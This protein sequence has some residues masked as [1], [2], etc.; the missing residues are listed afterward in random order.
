MINKMLKRIILILIFI[1]LAILLNCSSSYANGQGDGYSYQGENY[2][3]RCY[4]LNA[5]E[6][7]RYMYFYD[8]PTLF[9]NQWYPQQN[10]E[11]TVVEFLVDDITIS[12]TYNFY[13]SISFKPFESYGAD[14]PYNGKINF[15]KVTLR[16]GQY[17]T[18]TFFRNDSGAFIFEDIIFDGGWGDNKNGTIAYSPMLTLTGQGDNYLINCTLKN[19]C[20]MSTSYGGAISSQNA[21]N[22][23]TLINVDITNCQAYCGGAMFLGNTHLVYEGGEI[24]KCYSTNTGVPNASAISAEPS[25]SDYRLTLDGV[26]ITECMALNATIGGA[27]VASNRK[28][29]WEIKNIEITNNYSKALKAGF[30]IVEGNNEHEMSDVHITGDIIIDDNYGNCTFNGYEV[31]TKGAEANLCCENTT[32][33]LFIYLDCDFTS[34]TRCGVSTQW[35]QSIEDNDIVYWG[36]AYS[37]DIKGL[38]Y[39]FCDEDT[40]YKGEYLYDYHHFKEIYD[41]FAVFQT[42]KQVVY[43]ET[44]TLE[45][46][47]VGA[48]VD[49]TKKYRYRI[50][51][52]EDGVEKTVEVELSHDEKHTVKVDKNTEY[53]IE[54]LDDVTEESVEIIAEMPSGNQT[55]T[56]IDYRNNSATGKFDVDGSGKVTYIYTKEAAP[57]TGITDNLS[58]ILPIA[59]LPVTVVL[60]N[61]KIKFFV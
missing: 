2:Q 54:L 43:K 1:S 53:K 37:K 21:N 11:H 9:N 18:G 16:R 15:N 33:D 34:A 42:K 49:I 6:P 45:H 3:L 32:V 39:F 55:I 17:F 44:L 57:E 59:I 40:S 23:L 19:N 4:D 52:I 28:G 14:D 38:E 61:K 58:K 20:N 50:T 51:Y 56:D 22:N 30:G 7:R 27:A 41:D 35:D 47:C 26:K 24:T 8:L 25:N 10:F 12:Q 46:K 13:I 29:T 60:I 36:V 31:V 48:L 5:E